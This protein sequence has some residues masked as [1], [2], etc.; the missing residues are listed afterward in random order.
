MRPRSRCSSASA[1]LARSVSAL[2]RSVSAAVDTVPSAEPKP[3]LLAP[4]T[5]VRSRFDGLIAVSP[6]Q[7]PAEQFLIIRIV[8]K[9]LRRSQRL[10]VKIAFLSSVIGRTAGRGQFDRDIRCAIVLAPDRPDPSSRLQARALHDEHI[11]SQKIAAFGLFHAVVQA[12]V[13][14][15]EEVGPV[16]PVVLQRIHQQVDTVPMPCGVQGHTVRFGKLEG[17]QFFQTQVIR[18]CHQ[19][20][21]VEL[22]FRACTSPSRAGGYGVISSSFRLA[23]QCS[24][25]LP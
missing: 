13:A 14:G 20:G 5:T 3:E 17:F 2:A 21:H 1:R 16:S 11:R 19:W 4:Q 8:D 15:H 9:I 18:R 25:S 22:T 12:H 10:F 7:T 23:L 24:Q 6:V